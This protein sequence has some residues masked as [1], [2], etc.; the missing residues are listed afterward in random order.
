MP[1]NMLVFKVGKQKYPDAKQEY[2]FE[3]LDE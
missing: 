2:R 3:M 1:H